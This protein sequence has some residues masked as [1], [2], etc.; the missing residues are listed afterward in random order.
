MKPE[1]GKTILVVDD[2]PENIGIL[3][4]ILKDEYRV[5]AATGGEEALKI[6]RSDPPPDLIL[7]DIAM[8]GMDGFETCRALKQDE[9]GSG[10][11]VIFL[12]ATDR[13]TE[14]SKGFEAG[15]VDFIAKPVDSKVV[16]SRIKVHLEMREEAVRASEIRYRRLFETA[17]DGIIIVDAE[18][19]RIL[20]VNPYMVELLGFS[21]EDYLGKK[22]GDPGF[23]GGIAA[24]LTECRDA[25]QGGS[26]G[27][28]ALSL[29]AM[30]GR[31][32]DAELVCT[33]YQVNH[34]DVVQCNV[35]DVTKRKR[36]EDEIRR[37]N[38]ELEQRVIDRTAQLDASNKELEAFAY[39]ISHD[40]KAPLRAISGF[41]AILM[42]EHRAGL[43]EEGR[44]LLGVVY[45]SSREMETLVTDILELSRV[46]RIE[47]KYSR[48]D[49][50][51]MAWAMY[52]EIAS[53]EE[54]AQ[55]SFSIGAIPDAEGDPTM[56]RL[57]WGNLL[58]NAVKYSGRSA[59][60]SIVVDADDDGTRTIY[61][62]ADSG[63]GFDMAYSGKLFNVFQRLHSAQ[64][65]EGTGVGLAI[66]KRIIE[67]H[68]GR[69]GAE[70]RVGEGSS[71]WFSLPSRAASSAGDSA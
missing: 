52:C 46:G 62:V 42:D 1:R 60:R 8:P 45:D 3:K 44:R 5:R 48:I 2:V 59:Q 66:V 61:R 16:K 20:D 17:N 25:R 30:D 13:V 57:V 58:S 41:T 67:R 36:A 26:V 10:I 56:L 39:S 37:L 9:E 7:L 15:A 50:K 21:F 38:A 4:E 23:L 29:H 14:E 54:R 69:V 11:P 31:R 70:G 71:F 35:R 40:L 68:G 28:Y 19:G 18:S 49:M 53:I 32:I 34:R 24:V 47:L 27:Y 51:A 12:T 33:T 6:A 65:Y 55:F 64:E 43:D 63:V 22:L